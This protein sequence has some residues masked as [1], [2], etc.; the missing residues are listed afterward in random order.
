MSPRPWWRVACVLCL[1]FAPLAVAQD[2]SELDEFPGLLA[3]YSS[4]GEHVQ[5]IDRSLSFDW[6]PASPD[7][8][9]N[10]ATDL[11]AKWSG[12]LLVL[13]PGAVSYTHLTLPTKA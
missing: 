10:A 5:R 11:Q 13:N 3:T 4:G 6:G 2:E 1:G 7:E 9:L 12:R 8:R